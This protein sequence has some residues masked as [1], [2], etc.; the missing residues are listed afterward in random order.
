LY[1]ETVKETTMSEELL[2][3]QAM[4][5]RIYRERSTLSQGTRLSVQLFNADANHVYLACD[6]EISDL[7]LAA[8]GEDVIKHRLESVFMQLADNLSK[9][10]IKDLRDSGDLDRMVKR[11]G[12]QQPPQ[13]HMPRN[14]TGKS[15][16]DKVM[17]TY[18]INSCVE[19]WSGSLWETAVV[20]GHTTMM[21]LRMHSTGLLYDMPYDTALTDVRYPGG[22]PIRTPPW[23]GTPSKPAPTPSEK[24]STECPDCKGLGVIHLFNSSVPCDTC[25]GTGT[26]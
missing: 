8:I 19:V 13:P 26:V 12:P 4:Q 6:A 15:V 3:T 2:R 24:D 21:E 14:T 16:R 23:K 17:D 20:V 9:K 10:Y 1:P 18:P 22:S 25:N 11:A 5:I 7:E